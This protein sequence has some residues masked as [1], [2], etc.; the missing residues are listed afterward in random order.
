MNNE[1]VEVNGRIIKKDY[2]EDIIKICERCFIILYTS[3]LIFRDLSC[4]RLN[5]KELNK[6]LDHLDDME[7]ILTGYYGDLNEIMEE[8]NG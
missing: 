7:N 5:E 8:N 2:L 3:R 6:L 1:K 4:F